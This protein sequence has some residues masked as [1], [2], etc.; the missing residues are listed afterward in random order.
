MARSTHVRVDLDS[1]GICH[2]YNP[3]HFGDPAAVHNV[4][5]H[6]IVNTVGEIPAPAIASANHEFVRRD[7]FSVLFTAHCIAT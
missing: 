6:N 5:L 3:A 4:R 2:R 7:C 1:E